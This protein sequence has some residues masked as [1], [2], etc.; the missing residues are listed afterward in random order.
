[1]ATRS[2]ASVVRATRQPS[3]G[4][5]TTQSSGTKTWSR[6]TWLNIWRPVISRSGLM[7]MPGLSI[8]TRK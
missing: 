4:A 6:N 5:P 2:E 3:P 1:M 8:A 7:S